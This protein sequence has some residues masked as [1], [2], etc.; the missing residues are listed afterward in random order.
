MAVRRVV[1]HHQLD[2]VA[3]LEGALLDHTDVDEQIAQLLL[4]VGNAE[5]RVLGP[6]DDALVADLAAGLAVKGSLV[7]HQR[8]LVPRLQARDLLAVLQDCTDLSLGGFRVVAQE[9]GGADA[10]F[11]LKPDGLGRGLAGSLPGL[12]RLLLLFFIAVSKPAVSTVMPRALER[13]LR[14]VEREAVGVVESEGSLAG[15]H[16]ALLQVCGSPRRAGPGPS[17]GS[18]G[19]ASPP[20]SA[21][22]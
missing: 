14:Q 5:Q 9:I 7:Q 8:R 15:E 20:A 3:G 16:I 19:I 11:D 2:T 17:P 18:C 21:S 13:V 12:A 1:I 22:R 6:L 10:L 4:R